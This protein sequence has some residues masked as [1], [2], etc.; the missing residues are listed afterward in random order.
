MSRRRVPLRCWFLGHGRWH[1][2]PRGRW[3]H[4]CGRCVH[5]DPPDV[6]I[7]HRKPPPPAKPDPLPNPVQR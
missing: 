6:V 4:V 5:L 1:T 3:R 7:D 2:V